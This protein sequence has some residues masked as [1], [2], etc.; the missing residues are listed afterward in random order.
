MKA[1]KA[2]LHPTLTTFF[3]NIRKKNSE[4]YEPD[5]ISGFQ[6]SIQRYLSDKRSPVNILKDKDFET[7]RKVLAAKRK[8]LIHDHEKG[9]KPQAAQALEDNEEDVLFETREFGDTNP[10][11]LQRTVW[12]FL[13]LHFGFR[14]RDESRKLRW[15]DVQLTQDQ[16]GREMLVWLAERGTK[17]RHGQEKGHQRAFQPKVFAT[18]TERCPVK[19]YK[20]FKSHRPAEMNEPAAPSFYLAVRHNRSYSDDVWY[21]KSPLGK[22]EIGKFIHSGKESWSP[23]RGKEGHQPFGKKDMH[24]QASRCRCSRELCGTTQWPQKHG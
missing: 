20:K 14:A 2:Y 16:D 19:Y 21:M 24:F 6:R 22:N 12:W 15:G 11:S 3:M 5:T 23:E 1:L 18:N 10:V 17:T 13:S 7:S 9:N 4:E 8:S